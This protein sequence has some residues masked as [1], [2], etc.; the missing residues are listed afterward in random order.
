MI[1]DVCVIGSG[2]GAGPIIYELSKKGLKV[3]VLEKGDIYNE[4]DFSKDEIVVRKAIYTPNLKDE[5]HTI[6]ELMDNSWQKFPT[7]ETGWNFWNGSLLGG[8]SNFMSGYFHRLKPNDFKL[9]SIYGVAKKSNIVDWVISYEELEPYYTKVEE[10]VG[11]S[12]EVQEYEFLEPRSTKDFPYSA[13]AEN[14]IVDL[15]DKSCKELGF[16]SIKTPRAIISKQKDHR[17]PC[18]YSNYCGSYACSS[19]AKGSSR[20]SL[21]KDAI[22]TNNV[23]I[24]ANAFVVKLNTSK[25]KKIKS[26]TYLTK[27]GVKK[28][29]K[30]KLFILAAQAVETSRLLLNSKDENFP[31]GVANNSLNVGKNFLS[32]SGGIVSATFDETNINLKDLQEPGLFVNR[33]LMDWY[34]TKEFKTGTIDILFEHA[35]PIRRASILRWNEDE[36]L[37]GENLQNKIF[38][39]FTK[40][41]TLNMEIFVDWTPNDDSF[42][43]VDEKYKDKY[44]IPVANIRIGSHEQDKKA[45]IFLEEKAIKLFEKMGG[46]NIISDISVLPSSNLQAGG[47]RFGNDPKT[48]VLN[49]YCQAHEV[50]NLFVTDGSFMP[51]GGSVP[52]TWTIYANSFRVADYIKNNWED[53]IV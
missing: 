53:L 52:Y 47:C 15:I 13:L 17:N 19:G 7:Y 23:T 35:N 8:S 49:K 6:E 1:Y 36:L 37:I 11:V 4:K 2:A 32:S 26:A 10:L 27:E 38:E 21:I 16:K 48:S 33:S 28:E 3:C 41:R 25:D 20:A 50:S 31:F 22:L 29:I 9:A 51:T 44:G 30:A 12:G 42:I 43:S 39:T 45:S 40:T 14:K 46:K 34:F 24:I 18:Y 5:Y